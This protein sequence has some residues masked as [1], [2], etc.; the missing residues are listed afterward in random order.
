MS[1][2][3]KPPELVDE[4]KIALLLKHESSSLASFTTVTF[5]R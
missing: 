5:Q 3:S 4:L 2:R 1:L